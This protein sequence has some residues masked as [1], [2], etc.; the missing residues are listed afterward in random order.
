MAKW[1]MGVCD[2]LT[3]TKSGNPF[4]ITIITANAMRCDLCVN[5]LY[6]LLMC[7]VCS[8]SLRSTGDHVDNI[9]DYYRYYLFD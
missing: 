1:T 5:L 6:A 4:I 9:R 3:I 8:V 2:I 7:S